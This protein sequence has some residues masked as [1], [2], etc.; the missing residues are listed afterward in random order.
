MKWIH[1]CSSPPPDNCNP[2]SLIHRAYLLRTGRGEAF[3]EVGFLPFYHLKP[4]TTEHVGQDF[5]WGKGEAGSYSLDQVY[6]QSAPLATALL[7]T[8]GFRKTALHL[9]KRPG[10]RRFLRRPPSFCLMCHSHHMEDSK[11]A[12]EM[13]WK[14]QILWWCDLAY[15]QSWTHRV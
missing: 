1:W 13:L 6:H 12:K 3:Y 11:V 9:L 7:E 5:T 15:Q 4:S 2:V 8:Q 14:V 10:H